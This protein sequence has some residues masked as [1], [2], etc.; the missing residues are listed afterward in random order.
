MRFAADQALVSTAALADDRLYLGS[1][2][3]RLV[4]ID[5]L[6]KEYPLE[7]KVRYWQAQAWAWGLRDSLPNP[8]GLV[9]IRSF[10]RRAAIGAPAVVGDTV[11]ITLSVGPK[12]DHGELRALD[13]ATGGKER[14]WTY[15][16]DAFV[17][18]SP[19]VVGR[20]IYFGSKDGKLHAVDRE[21]GE[22]L[23]VLQAAKGDIS[24]RP[25]VGSDTLFVAS[26]DG[27]LYAIR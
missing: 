10:G 3:G 8:R 24:T 13:T 2:L 11:Y 17:H 27:T 6:Q 26:R 21:T 7:R 4:A 1:A 22:A 25:V 16:A 14:T 12:G 15:H 18:S 23:W 19:T 20:W 9:W 5:P